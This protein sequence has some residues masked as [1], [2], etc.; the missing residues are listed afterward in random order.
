MTRVTFALATIMAMAACDLR[1]NNPPPNEPTVVIQPTP[2][3]I[4]APVI[5]TFTSDSIQ[6]LANRVTALRWDVF[7]Q[8]TTCRIDPLIGNV[9]L[10][11]FVN[12]FVNVTVTYRLSCTNPS[13]TANR[14]L[15]IVV[16]G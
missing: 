3:P 1:L 14:E 6:I 4:A 12:V 2:T 5:T 9:P 8:Q 11:G 7:G 10:T 15:T 13:G 16:V